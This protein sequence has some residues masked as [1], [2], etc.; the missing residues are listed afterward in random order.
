MNIEDMYG[1]ID[2]VV[3][4]RVFEKY[5]NL[6]EEDNIALIEGS[7][8]LSS[9]GRKSIKVEKLTPIEEL[10]KSEDK[11]YLRLNKY[12]KDLIRD[13]SGILYKYKGNTPVY[14]FLEESRKTIIGDRKNWVNINDKDLLIDL[15]NYLGKD[16]V[17][18]VMNSK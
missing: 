12:N 10:K 4:P 11:L 13:I 3:F 16:N 2:T 6:I 9:D 17:K 7:Y 5:K 14:I 18:I 15:E 1:E 8:N